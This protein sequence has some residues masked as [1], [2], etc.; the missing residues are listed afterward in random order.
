LLEGHNNNV[1]KD[2]PNLMELEG[3]LPHSQ[4]PAILI[5]GLNN[6]ALATPCHLK[7]YFNIILPSM[8]GF[9]KWYVSIRYLHQNLHPCHTHAFLDF[10]S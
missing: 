5:V 4:T 2:F 9:S 6:P 3:S 1:V 7:I 10:I 8:R